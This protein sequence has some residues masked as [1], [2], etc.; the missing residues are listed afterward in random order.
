[1]FYST[2]NETLD[3]IILGLDIHTNDRV[4]A[5]GGS[6]DQAFA[7]AASGASVVAVDK[8]QRQVE[9]MEQRHLLLSEGRV[10]E[11]LQAYLTPTQ[12]G[13]N[14]YDFFSQRK[15]SLEE[16]H[17]NIVIVQKNIFSMNGTFDKIYL[18]N[19]MGWELKYAAKLS[20]AHSLFVQAYAAVLYPIQVILNFRA[21]RQN[22]VPGG[23]LYLSSPVWGGYDF[24]PWPCGFTMESALT[25]KARDLEVEPM[26]EP[27]VLRKI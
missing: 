2:T 10:N 25:R 11:F 20:L 15:T 23:L 27:V 14:S 6:G 4:L 5:V 21:L 9:F 7:L 26:W 16:L 8:R 22:L 12:P 24:Y 19:A 13:K 1:M 3:A 18:S 17:E